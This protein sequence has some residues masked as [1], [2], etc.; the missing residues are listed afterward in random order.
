[1][2]DLFPLP[3]GEGETLPLVYLFLTTALVKCGRKI[4]F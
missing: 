3:A 2:A 4:K 1:M